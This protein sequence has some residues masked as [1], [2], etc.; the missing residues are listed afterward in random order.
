MTIR[1]AAARASHITVAF[2]GFSAELGSQ[3]LPSDVGSDTHEVA[4]SVAGPA[5]EQGG[6]DA[7]KGRG[8]PCRCLRTRNP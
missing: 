5:P 1:I 7:W 8:A 6:L 3:V 2:G 4:Q